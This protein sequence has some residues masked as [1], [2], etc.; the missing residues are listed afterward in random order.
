MRFGR[1]WL[2]LGVLLGSCVIPDVE[3]VDSPDSTSGASAS[4][5]EGGASNHAGTKG[6]TGKAGSANPTTG[7]GG[8]AD[9][10]QGGEPSF[11][12]T[13][14]S[15]GRATGGAG[16]SGT[17]GGTGGSGPVPPGAVAKFCNGVTY[18]GQ[19]VDL[20]LRIG[21]GASTVRM[22]A[23]TGTCQPVVPHDCTPI[24]TGTKALNVYFPDGTPF[25]TDST[26][27]IKAGQAWVFAVYYDDRTQQGMFDGTPGSPA[28][29]AEQ[30]A[31]VDYGPPA[32]PGGA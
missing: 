32:P 22:V 25:W 27:D 4:S 23:S 26:A 21:T 7:A 5:N 12:A 9:I 18:L 13:A 11:G 20:E 19:S 10:G 1:S 2:L 3:I 28:L 16:G 15:G 8:A 30:C 31:A 17:T 6:S 29:T 24:T 14:T